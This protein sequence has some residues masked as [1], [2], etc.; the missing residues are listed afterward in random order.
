MS[1]LE[2][3]DVHGGTGEQTDGVEAVDAVPLARSMDGR[4]RRGAG[5]RR[6][7]KVTVRVERVDRGDRQR[8]GADTGVGWTR[9]GRGQGRG[10]K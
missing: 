5:Q 1:G 9:Q 6:G 4:G 7:G 10:G 3:W 8:E 2:R